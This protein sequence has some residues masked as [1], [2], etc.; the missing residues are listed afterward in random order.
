MVYKPTYN[1][2]SQT[3][4]AINGKLNGT[5]SSL[6]PQQNTDFPSEALPPITAGCLNWA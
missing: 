5:S 3:I 1:W 2:D 4:D 6:L